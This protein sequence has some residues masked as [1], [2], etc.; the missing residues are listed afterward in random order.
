MKTGMTHS[1]KDDMYYYMN[2]IQDCDELLEW[3]QAIGDWLEEK[4]QELREQQ[5]REE[6]Q[7]T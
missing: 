6:Q 7:R 3:I 5:Q 1:Q 2:R 4:T